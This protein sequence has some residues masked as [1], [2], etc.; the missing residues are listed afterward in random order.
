MVGRCANP[1]C[2]ANFRYLHDGRIFAIDVPAA[3]FHHSGELPTVARPPCV[4]YFWLCGECLPYMT[5]EY[6]EASGS[7]SIRHRLGGPLSDAQPLAITGGKGNVIKKT[8]EQITE[9]PASRV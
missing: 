6:D 3:R 1:Q 2:R 7:V 5:V 8:D 4:Q 9:R